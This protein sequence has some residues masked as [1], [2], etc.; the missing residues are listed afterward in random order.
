MWRATTAQSTCVPMKGL[1]WRT[2][3]LQRLE[4]YSHFGLVELALGYAVSH[5]ALTRVVNPVAVTPSA[6]P[7]CDY[8]QVA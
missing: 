6:Q 2:K 4:M 1:H 7:N 8:K 3:N 5:N